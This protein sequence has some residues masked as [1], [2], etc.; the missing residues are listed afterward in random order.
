M[1][2]KI[3]IKGSVASVKIKLNKPDNQKISLL[4]FKTLRFC[5]LLLTA[6]IGFL[7]S[8]CDRTELCLTV[9]I[10]TGACFSR[11]NVRRTFR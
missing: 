8:R 10:K 1:M 3:E 2:R 5:K 4:N 6:R 11:G 9:K 7:L